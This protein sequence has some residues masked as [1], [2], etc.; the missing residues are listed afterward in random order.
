MILRESDLF[1]YIKCPLRYQILSKGN[2]LGENKSFKK[3]CYEAINHYYSAK[4]NGMRADCNTL[5]RKWD[6]IAINNKET[7]NSKKV[8]EGWGMLY[9]AYEYINNYNIEFTAI[10]HSYSLEIPGTGVCLTGVLDPIIDKGD[11]IELFITSFDKQIPDRTEIDSRLKHTIDAYVIKELF[12]KDTVI[13]YYIPAQ[14]KNIKSLRS[15]NDFNRL[16]SILKNVG[17]AIN[18][19]IIYP[20]ETFTCNMCNA[21][22]ACKAWTGMEVK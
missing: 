22:A 15:T 3:L 18:A 11:Y 7:I 5:K 1:E 6:N 13:N 2:K 8:L 4:S 12:K 21:K 17:K 20:R 9:R 16:E 10:N 14:G 19:N